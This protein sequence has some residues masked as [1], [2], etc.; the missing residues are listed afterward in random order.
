M[1]LR[2][3]QLPPDYWC[4]PRLKNLDTGRIYADISLGDEKWQPRKYNIPGDWHTTT[5]DG[6]P[7]CPLRE[8]ITFI[9]EK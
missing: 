4:R 3:K 6:E 7:D 9:L 2:V 1:E 8:D 5:R